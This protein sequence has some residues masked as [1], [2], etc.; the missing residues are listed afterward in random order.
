MRIDS[1]FQS[2]YGQEVRD[3]LGEG[4]EE[5]QLRGSNCLTLEENLFPFLPSSHISGFHNL[6]RDNQS[7]VDSLP[8]TTLKMKAVCPSKMSVYSPTRLC[9]VTN[10]KTSI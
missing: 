4:L 7:L 2:I 1:P 6:L 10:K 3:C 5:Y 8:Y 9:V